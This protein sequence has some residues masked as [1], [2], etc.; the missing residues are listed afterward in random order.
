MCG[1]AGLTSAKVRTSR[2]PSPSSSLPDM[3]SGTCFGERCTLFWIACASVSFLAVPGRASAP[4]SASGPPARSRRWRRALDAFVVRT[5]PIQR[6]T[7]HV[8]HTLN[9]AANVGFPKPED[10]PPVLRQPPGRR[11]VAFHVAADLRDPVVA[12]RATSE[13]PTSLRPILPVPEI[14]IAEHDHAAASEDDVGHGK[15]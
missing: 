13:L 7:D 10:Q 9:V 4:A 1:V 2:W 15:D 11:L 6:R 12:V 5:C 3:R 8:C 14:T